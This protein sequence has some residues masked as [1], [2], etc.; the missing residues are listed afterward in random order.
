MAKKKFLRTSWKN[1]SK[2]GKGRKK[3]QKYRKAKGRHNKI[4]LKRKGRLKR[5][6][7]GFR[8]RKKERGLVKGLKPVMIR[9]ITEL[10]RLQKDE[11]GIISKM[12]DKKK[13]E[14]LEYAIKNNIKLS[15]NAKEFLEKIDEKIK[16]SKENRRRIE[17]KKKSKMKKAEKKKDVK[18]QESKEELVK[19]E[20]DIK[21]NVEE[22][23]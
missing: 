3:K 9:N 12:G 2:L 5:V 10:K 22:K 23:K 4:R 15:I 21:E 8:S 7:I 14:I 18:K 19:H 6:E 13:R 11:I 17:E 20:N 16:K 1:Y